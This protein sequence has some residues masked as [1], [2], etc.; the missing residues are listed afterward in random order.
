MMT[1]TELLKEKISQSG[2]KIGY[3]AES[4]G[5]SRASLWNKVNN[6]RA[7]TVPEMDKL[8][9]VLNIKSLRERDAIFFNHDV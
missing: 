9:T 6:L 1:D 4:T 8:C 2:L 7:F 5:I 3:I